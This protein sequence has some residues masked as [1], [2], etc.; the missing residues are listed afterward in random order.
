MKIVVLDAMSRL[1]WY[2]DGSFG[3]VREKV[4]LADGGW[5][6]DRAPLQEKHGAKRWA[7]E[8]PLVAVSLSGGAQETAEDLTPLA[9]LG[10]S[11]SVHE[12][13]ARAERGVNVTSPAAFAAYWDGKGARVGRKVKGELLWVEPPHISWLD[14]EE[15]IA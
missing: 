14:Y 1:A 7:L 12:L 13:E 8:S 4:R 15:A 10:G 6:I 9:L 3:L 2:E 11:V 5:V